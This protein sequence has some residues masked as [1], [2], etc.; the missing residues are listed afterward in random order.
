[1]MSAL[2]GLFLHKRQL[3]FLGTEE[4]LVDF[5]LDLVERLL[6]ILNFNFLYLTYNYIIK[7]EINPKMPE[8]LEIIK[9]NKS[10]LRRNSLFKLFIFLFLFVY[11]QFQFV[12][13]I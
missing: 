11:L 3:I 10:R 12:Y 1:M 9:R 13:Y 7:D 6:S 4:F 8:M 2:L 5:L